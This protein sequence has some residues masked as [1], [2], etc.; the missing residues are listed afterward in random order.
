MTRN[1]RHR[2]K[3]T[4]RDT[5]QT[6]HTTHNTRHK[7]HHD[8][9]QPTTQDTLFFFLGGTDRR[10]A[11]HSPPLRVFAI[12]YL[13]GV[14]APQVDSNHV[15]SRTSDS[16]SELLSIRPRGPYTHTRTHARTHARTHTHILDKKRA[17][18]RT[19]SALE[20]RGLGFR[21]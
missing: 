13:A 6:T 3:D 4:P 18:Y 15:Q 19:A 16:E 7:T 9:T 12:P 14:G 1:T 5:H 11:S 10:R 21:V 2:T 8:N 17:T 20:S